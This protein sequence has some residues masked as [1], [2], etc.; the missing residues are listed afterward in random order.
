MCGSCDVVNA[1][2]YFCVCTRWFNRNIIGYKSHNLWSSLCF[3]KRKPKRQL[4]MEW[5]RFFCNVPRLFWH[6]FQGVFWSKTYTHSHKKKHEKN[7]K[8]EKIIQNFNSMKLFWLFFISKRSH[9][10]H[11]KF[12]KYIRGQINISQR[13]KRLKMNL[14]ETK[15]RRKFKKPWNRA[16]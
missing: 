10:P 12:N 16:N 2:C 3:L 15:N 11:H 13:K 8:L 4:F 14:N 9:A 1:I 7:G 6:L 5:F